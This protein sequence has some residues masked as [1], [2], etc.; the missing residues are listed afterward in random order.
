MNQNPEAHFSNPSKP[1]NNQQNW[2][3]EED[4]VSN[5]THHQENLEHQGNSE[6][7]LHRQNLQSRYSNIESKAA[8]QEL[9]E[10]KMH[11]FVYFFSKN[12]FLVIVS[13]LG[14]I[15]LIGIV[16]AQF[17]AAEENRPSTLLG[18]TKKTPKKVEEVKFAA[19]FEECKN[20]GNPI[21]ESFPPR[22]SSGG[23]TF[24]Q[25]LTPDDK[26]K[27]TPPA[28][29]PE[30]KPVVVKTKTYASVNYPNLKITYPEN[31]KIDLKNESFKDADNKSK[32]DTGKTYVL[33]IITFTKDN[34]EVQYRITPVSFGGYGPVT[35][36]QKNIW[37]KT[38]KD[39]L[40]RVFL[41]GDPGVFKYTYG[42]KKIIS[43]T[44]PDLAGLFSDDED[45]PF[46]IPGKPTD[47]DSCY[48]DDQAIEAGTIVS[49]YTKAGK[50]LNAAVRIDFRIKGE[51]LGESIF[52][53]VD[54]MVISSNLK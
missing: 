37:N 19:S 22:C 51:N 24:T 48:T 42:Y 23:K 3:V 54:G 30:E 25:E 20:L 17:V 31:W 4:L 10:I 15:S 46:R 8:N 35:A 36:C 52:K 27:V 26:T 9:S 47:Y 18:I 1:E 32:D 44:S 53:E 11:P 2:Q 5:N 40:G 41:E 13:T 16:T 43:P 45:Q 38:I 28:P 21:M 49:N 14:L 33:G 7:A 29:K 34:Y 39:K 50:K 6:S 12:K